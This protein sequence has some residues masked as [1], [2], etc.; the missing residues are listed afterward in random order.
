MSYIKACGKDKKFAFRLVIGADIPETR[1]VGTP[2]FKPHG[3][4]AGVPFPGAALQ[5]QVHSGANHFPTTYFEQLEVTSIQRHSD[6]YIKLKEYAVDCKPS[7]TNF[8]TRL[9]AT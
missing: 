3:H 7:R 6:G 8:E 5:L 1:L 2:D 4:N 9:E